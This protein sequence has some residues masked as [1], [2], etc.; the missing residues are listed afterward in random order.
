[1][2]WG[3]RSAGCQPA[4]LHRPTAIEI[5]QGYSVTEPTKVD[6]DAFRATSVAGGTK[7]PAGSLRYATATKP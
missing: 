5:P 3:R 7:T 1:M 4:F 6:S 2:I